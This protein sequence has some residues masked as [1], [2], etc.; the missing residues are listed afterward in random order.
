MVV[1][2]CI[3]MLNLDILINQSF[4]FSR[5]M[6]IRTIEQIETESVFICK[7]VI[8]FRVR[9]KYAILRTLLVT[10][11]YKRSVVC[12]HTYVTT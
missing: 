7:R 9:G 3:S 2:F 1:S 4:C 12:L 8:V 5:Y 6:N 10:G 11:D